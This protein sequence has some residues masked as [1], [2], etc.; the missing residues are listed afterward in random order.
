MIIVISTI[1]FLKLLFDLIKLESKNK[2]IL[3]SKNKKILESNDFWR[4]W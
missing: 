4:L 3:E 2:K 1:K